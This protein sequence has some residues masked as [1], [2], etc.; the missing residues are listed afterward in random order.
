MSGQ[1]HLFPRMQTSPGV[2]PSQSP[3]HSPRH[4]SRESSRDANQAPGQ[5]RSAHP[6][7]C[8]ASIRRDRQ[9]RVDSVLDAHAAN[10]AA[11]QP[12]PPQRVGEGARGASA[13]PPDIVK[14]VR[15]RAREVGWML[16]KRTKPKITRLSAL[17]HALRATSYDED[18]VI[19]D[20]LRASEQAG[21]GDKSEQSA[22]F[23]VVREIA[24]LRALMR[25]L[26][27]LQAEH[28]DAEVR[29]STGELMARLNGG[30]KKALNIPVPHVVAQGPSFFF[31]AHAFANTS[32]AE[33]MAGNVD[34][35]G[36]SSS[37]D[38]YSQCSVSSSSRAPPIRGSHW[39][40]AFAEALE[41]QWPLG[42]PHI[43]QLLQAQPQCGYALA[44]TFGSV[45]RVQRSNV[46]E[47]D[48]HCL[49][50]AGA[51]HVG[52]YPLVC[53]A[54]D[55]ALAACDSDDACCESWLAKGLGAAPAKTQLLARF[56]ARLCERPWHLTASDVALFVDEY[57]RIHATQADAV[58]VPRRS[59]SSSVVA[60]GLSHKS[61]E[62]S[63]LRDLLHAV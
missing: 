11:G 51:A 3:Y 54:E 58:T 63:A 61:F 47:R 45:F 13:A 39:A 42:P 40:R 55:R 53:L 1:Q 38:E 28:P 16:G 41:A 7:N 49:F 10:V 37:D 52:C 31:P 60:A 12:S 14:T 35:E 26:V 25:S 20:A 2:S 36:D 22:E 6:H 33:N 43:F 50:A 32:L 8:W 44:A 9:A 30:D 5:N 27:R 62:E 21:A 56:G 34:D 17:A 15:S 57:V 59:L 24:A 23:E 46:K 48:A 19:G 4:S 18:D 29:R